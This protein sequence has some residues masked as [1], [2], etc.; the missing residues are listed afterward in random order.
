MI[1]KLLRALL[2]LIL[3]LIPFKVIAS[4]DIYSN[5]E[6]EIIDDVRYIKLSSVAIVH[7]LTLQWS[8]SDKSV[9]T[10]Y[11]D[12][13]L[14]F[15]TNNDIVYINDDM[16]YFG[17]IKLIKGYTYVPQNATVIFNEGYT[18]YLLDEPVEYKY[19]NGIVTKIDVEKNNITT[20]VIKK[21]LINQI[22]YFCIDELAQ[23][24]NIE[25]VKAQNSDYIML[26]NN[27]HE[28]YFYVQSDNINLNGT[29]IT[30]DNII[31]MDNRYYAP[32]NLL[33][34]LIETFVTDYNNNT[35]NPTTSSEDESLYTTYIFDDPSVKYVSMKQ[36]S[37]IA[38]YNYQWYYMNRY[39][40]IE[41]DNDKFFI[42]V[43][44]SIIMKDDLLY[45]GYSIKE[46]ND[47]VYIEY[48]ALEVFGL[49]HK[50]DIEDPSNEVLP[51]EDDQNPSESDLGTKLPSGYIPIRQF[52][53]YINGTVM[54]DSENFSA[55]LTHKDTEYTFDTRNFKIY[56][57]EIE[58]H[59]YD[60]KFEDGITHVNTSL[61]ELISSTNI[62][63]KEYEEYDLIYIKS[64]TVTLKTH[65]PLSDPNRIVVDIA[66]C[67]S[68]NNSESVKGQFFNS[69]RVLNEP[70]NLKRIVFDLISKNNYE[71]SKTKGVLEVKVFKTGT[72]NTQPSSSEQSGIVPGSTINDENENTKPNN[73]ADIKVETD[74]IIVNTL[75]YENYE[76]KRIS[77]PNRIV[78]FIPNSFSDIKEFPIKENSRYIKKVTSYYSDEGLYIEVELSN[79]CRYEIIEI[80]E[81]KLVMDIYSQK[82]INMSYYNYSDRKYINITG[83]SLAD[84][85]GVVNSNVKVAKNEMITTIEFIDSNYRLTAGVLYVND[86]FIEKIQVKRINEKVI[87]TIFAK[88]KIDLYF[89]SARTSYTNIN[90][91]PENMTYSGSVVIDAGHG[92]YDPGA[93][94]SSVYESNIN[95]KIAL[96][97]QAILEN[98]NINVFMMRKTDEYVG[99][100]ERAH[101]ANLIE[102]SLFVSIHSNAFSNSAY[103]GIMTLVYPSSV[104][105]NKLSGKQFGTVLQKNLIKAT[106]A[107]DRGVID[108]PNLIVLNS[109]KM[110]ASLVECGFM[111]NAEELVALQSEEYQ[112]ILAQGIAAGIIEALS[113]K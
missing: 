86:D 28:V 65:Y 52:A 101:V 40:V 7:K 12:K 22:E 19:I 54:W 1:K 57:N 109:T 25:P 36:V 74:K 103:K 85:Y 63:Y 77:D 14:I 58:V 26:M 50:D 44:S 13:N 48:R 68:V 2:I 112:N 90:F 73:K 64:P 79:Q 10:T 6:Y 95:L 43:P 70:D 55:I 106:S 46:D 75:D 104:Q 69:I 33:K 87:M 60:F 34:F 108:R 78:L 4:Q 53:E 56:V 5:C 94:A 92:G 51:D 9:R 21:Y 37:D 84:Q 80:S 107:I 59:G 31:Y 99:L 27:E 102:A 62:L 30:T 45:K 29:N 96:K 100:Y 17:E 35:D 88:Q 39:A 105:S 8:D 42:L 66:D 83:L 71:I 82:I 47:I 32:N 111:T 81:T 97:V 76:I 41:R 110:P 18:A 67:D 61:E 91:I 16:Y 49:I 72:N 24:F 3:L 38:G 20:S 11:N 15:S 98:N 23:F 89:N 93:V 113:L